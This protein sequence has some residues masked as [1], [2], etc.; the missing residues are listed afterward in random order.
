MKFM[1]KLLVLSTVLVATS[2]CTTAQ[3]QSVQPM[4]MAASIEDGKMQVMH[5][6]VMGEM[7]SVR[8]RL[9]RVERAMIRLDRRMQLVE[10]N[11]LGR[12]NGE[13]VSSFQN[14]GNNL[15][16]P[17]V[18]S[19]FKP[20]NFQQAQPAQQQYVQQHPVKVP[21]QYPAVQ[22][23][24]PQNNGYVQQQGARMMPMA[25]NGSAQQGQITS[26]LQAAPINVAAKTEL[27]TQ[28]RQ[29]FAGLPSLA[30]TTE[31]KKSDDA[32]VAIWTIGYDTRK[33]WPA[34][35]QLTGSREVVEALRAE[36][37]VALFARGARPASKEFRERVRAL[38]RYLSRVSNKDS[39]PI[40]SLPAEHL[41][42]DTIEILATK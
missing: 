24:M 18:N 42:G 1:P 15:P 37:P 26:S 20:M 33:I 17:D 10:R 34:R 32:S 16:N 22:P 19:L 11:E 14:N 2:A 3:Q 9:R 25:Y 39:I 8:E 6:Q 31:D 28:K 35:D 41:D 38:S 13:P 4:P 36:K 27:S 21:G 29:A 5:S 7:N 12:M 30:D 23:V 40:A